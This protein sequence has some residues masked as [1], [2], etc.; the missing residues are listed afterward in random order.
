MLCFEVILV[1]LEKVANNFVKVVIYVV[2]IVKIRK[3]KGN[4]FLGSLKISCSQF[5]KL[6]NI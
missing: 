4:I 6:G 3:M 5:G 1:I 2:K